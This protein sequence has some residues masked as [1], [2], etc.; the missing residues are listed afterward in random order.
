M[1][2]FDEGSGSTLA[3]V[4]N[5][6]AGTA[7]EG[8]NQDYA[9]RKRKEIAMAGH[10]GRLTSGVENYNLGDIGASQLGELG[11]VQ[12]NLADAL[13][14][15]PAQ[16]YATQQDDARK[17]ELAKL[18]GEMSQSGGGALGGAL[19]GL[20]GALSGATTGATVGGPWGALAGGVIGGGLGAYGGTQKRRSF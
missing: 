14:G 3:D 20:S 7:T 11:G 16:D 10:S 4:L 8:I 1:G 2:L 13:A 17:L 9:K 12:S 5:R 15:I 18:I 6:Q 19:G